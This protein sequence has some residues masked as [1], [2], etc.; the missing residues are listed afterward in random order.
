MDV[1]LLFC[2]YMALFAVPRD[3]I[4]TPAGSDEEVWFGVVFHGVAAQRLALLHGLVYA[5]GAYGF[6]RMRAWMWPWAALYAGQVA[7]SAAAWPLLYRHD[8]R[9]LVLGAAFGFVALR[10]WRARELFRPAP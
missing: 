5:A 6:W 4:T 1:L 7:F 9:G 10:L 2:V 8:A 3:L